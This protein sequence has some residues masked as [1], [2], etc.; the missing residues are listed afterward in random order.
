MDPYERQHVRDMIGYK[1]RV[2]RTIDDAMADLG[3]RFTTTKGRRF[4]NVMQDRLGELQESL[5]GTIEGGAKNQWHLANTMNNKKIDG[6]LGAVKVSD[7]IQKSMR[8]PNVPALNAFIDRTVAGKN[9][10]TRV[11]DFKEGVADEMDKILS[12]GVLVGKPAV[13]VQREL[14][15]YINGKPILYEGTLIKARN[16][17]F[18]AIRLAVT[19]TNM[20]FRSADYLQNSRLP[21][22]TGVTVHL[23]NAH[24][25][26]DICDEMQGQYPKGFYFIGW[27]P[28]CYDSQTDVYTNEG[29]KRFK[30][31]RGDE[32]ILSLNP[33]TKDLEYTTIVHRIKYQYDGEMIRF[34]SRSFDMMVTPDHKMVG[35]D[36]TSGK[37]RESS[38]E[39]FY[40]NM[41][42]IKGRNIFSTN[43]KLYRSSEWKGTDIQ[44][45]TIG[46]HDIPADL[47][48]EFMAYYLSDGSISRKY[49]VIISQW[50]KASPDQ[51]E[52]ISAC[53]DR[54]QIKHKK[55]EKGFFFYDK[56][57]WEY[58]AKFGKSYEKYIPEIIKE[59]T[60]ERINTFLN[61][62]VLC[63][64][65]IRCGKKWKGGNFHDDRTYT[66]S[67]ERMAGDLGELILKIGHHPSFAIG[68]TKGTV[69]KH[70]NG[71]YA[72][73]HDQWVIRDCRSQYANQ[74]SREKI[75][76]SGYVYDIEIATNH[77]IYTRRNG[78]CSWGSNCI[79][80]STY[81]TIS[82][83]E[84]VNYIKTD[85]IKASRFTKRI[86]S[87]SQKY[88]QKNGERF[89]DYK[90]TPY[91]LQQNF[92][93][94]LALRESINI[95]ITAGKLEMIPEVEP[96]ENI[97]KK[98]RG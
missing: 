43:S 72:S 67:S 62:Y 80:Y 51:Y 50:K 49:A 92:T 12:R 35:F 93:K 76:Y 19:E 11:W 57:L 13:Q 69:T 86:P 3:R 71:E 59:L 2:A 30:D 61:A 77:I 96:I 39:E 95:P 52:I 7:A 33:D 91:W 56:D 68:S 29:W 94:G 64:G 85:K 97:T 90:T 42:P 37:L 75:Q 34:H 18:Q 88:I 38:A 28:F 89:L 44:G 10:S 46:K 21:F 55:S 87:R 53:M 9:L 4:A 73:N 27:H 16:L 79:C 40:Q 47:F 98:K 54:M 48:C 32:Q 8:A 1:K 78:K 25:Q 66:T 84:F 31:I 24:P 63:D 14:K 26:E 83:E 5:Q 20:A 70:W 23:S 22:V 81:D 45:I 65:S 15:K 41:Y 74:F 6:Y 17:T 82:K 58:L 60:P 36:K